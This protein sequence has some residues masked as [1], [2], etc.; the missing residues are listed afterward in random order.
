MDTKIL[1]DI[2]LTKNEIKVYLA[3]LES[4]QSS[5]GKILSKAN[6]QNS[7]FHFCINRLIEKGLVTFIKQG[8]IRLYNA[9]EPDSFITYLKDK[10]DLVKQLLPQL[11]AKQNV[12][13]DKNEAEVFQGMHGIYTMMNTLTDKS[14]KGDE[15]VFFAADVLEK[16]IEIGK[17]FAKF[18]IKRY[19]KGLITKLISPES[20]AHRKIFTSRPYV[21]AKYIDFPVPANS[22]VCGKMLAMISWE[23]TPIA[24]LIHSKQIAQKQKDFFDA[25]WKIAKD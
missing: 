20:K 19:E 14:K 18:D 25:M 13:E 11:K 17:F 23:E 2:G 7:V 6:I 24:I 8:K 4:G 12:S 15:F 1:E 16:N 9:A 3:L 22:I 21:T 10:E 5:A